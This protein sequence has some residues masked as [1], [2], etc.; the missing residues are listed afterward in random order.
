[1]PARLVFNVFKAI[2]LSM[3][4]VFVLDLCFYL[5]KALNLNQRMESTCVSLQKVITENNY[6][7]EGEYKMFMEIF[8]NIG[9]TMNGGRVSDSLGSVDQNFI[10]YQNTN[11]GTHAV[12]INYKDA[13]KNASSVP[14][15]YAQAY[16]RNTGNHQ[17]K[18]LVHSTLEDP[19]DYG[20]IMYIEV[21]VDILQPTWGFVHNNGALSG[22]SWD[23]IDD[24][25]TTTFTYNYLV[26]CLK[27]Q[28]VT[29]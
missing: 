11:G 28:S 17:Q 12:K 16:N 1:M 4:L 18:N 2:A 20:D 8:D 21:D 19:A 9:K 22:A 14:S 15:I 10:V 27:Y 23:R 5:Y 29:N 24:Y 3:I 6:L 13:P 7:P 26:P 25:A